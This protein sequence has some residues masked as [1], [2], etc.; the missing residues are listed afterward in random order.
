VDSSGTESDSAG[1]AT[2]WTWLAYGYA[3]LVACALGYGLLGMP[4]QVSDSLNNIVEASQGSL[5]R[6]LV[7]NFW[8]RGYLR[9]FLWGLIRV[10]FDLSNGHYFEWFRGWHVAQV[11]VLIGLFVA[12]LRVRRAT[13]AAVVPLGLAALIGIHTFWGTIREAFPINTFMTILLCCYGAVWL[14]LG[15]PRWWRDVAAALL[16]IFAALTVESGLL[17]GV[18]FVAAWLAGARGL[19][20]AGA[21]AQVAL[22][23]GYFVLRFLIL[24]IGSPGLT[25]R[26]SGFGFGVIDRAEL[27]ARFGANPLPFYAYNVGTSLLSLLISEPRGG[28]FVTTQRVL[29]GEWSVLNVVGVGASFLGTCL[30]AA[31]VWQRRGEW[32]ARRFTRDD[33]LVAIFLA[34]AA[35]NAVICYAYTKDVIL[36]PAGACY[37]LALA[38]AARHFLA[39]APV[40]AMRTAVASVVMLLLS[41]GWAFRAVAAQIDLRHAAGVARGEWVYVDRWLTEQNVVPATDAGRAIVTQLHD[42]AVF[43]HPM[44][45]PLVGHWVKWFEE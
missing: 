42:D 28:I 2:R 7:S 20:R 30:I 10:V 34:V 44:R 29:T 22:V 8:A 39:R 31:F 15:P 12:L 35:A 5:S 43:R 19:S 21:A 4:V 18:V 38:V 3:A 41:T 45:P 27:A 11:A 1:R 23:A 36:S 9:P 26:S 16:L 37:A 25:E 32:W 40:T 13:D 17:V 14:A 24:D 6:L 33:Q